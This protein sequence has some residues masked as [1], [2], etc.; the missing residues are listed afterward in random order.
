MATSIETWTAPT[1][2]RLRRMRLE[3]ESWEVIAEALAVTPEAASTRADRI[4]ARCPSS[5]QASR[6]DPAREP[7]PAGHPAAW[8]V[9]TEGTWLAGSRY[10]M[11][12]GMGSRS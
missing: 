1:D 12:A 10:P 11:P 4:A 2:F 7:L 5:G 9:L 8:H 3:G 6:Q